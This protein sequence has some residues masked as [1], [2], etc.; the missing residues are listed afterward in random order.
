MK[1]EATIQFQGKIAEV[2]NYKGQKSAKIICTQ[3]RLVISLKDCGDFE[4]GRKINIT[5]DL[6]INEI[7][8]VSDKINE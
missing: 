1:T 6:V 3:K 7:H 4:L 8:P 2:M 5:G